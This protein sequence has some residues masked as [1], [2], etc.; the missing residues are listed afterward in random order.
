MLGS[1]CLGCGGS[2]CSR[3]GRQYTSSERRREPTALCQAVSG[4]LL[5]LVLFLLLQTYPSV[6][7]FIYSWGSK[8][9]NNLPIITHLTSSVD[10]AP[11]ICQ[12]IK[13][14]G[15]VPVTVE[16]EKEVLSLL[17]WTKDFLLLFSGQVMS[18]S[19][20]PHGLQHTCPSLLPT[21]CSNSC[22]LSWWCY[23]TISSSATP[24]SFCL[25]SF[26]ASG[27]FQWVGSSHRWPKN[28]NFSFSTSPPSEYSGFISFRIHWFHLLKV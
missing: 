5:V 15:T 8:R 6:L 25:Q 13:E 16:K 19:L 28:W 27:S 24:F 1:F 2:D 10:W 20:Q 21:V 12:G 4:A 11:I 9:A 26:P 23:P 3:E 7:V 22:P 18:S 17:S 14:L